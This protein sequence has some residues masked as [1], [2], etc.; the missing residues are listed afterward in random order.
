[1]DGILSEHSIGLSERNYYWSGQIIGPPYRIRRPCSRMNAFTMFAVLL[2]GTSL[3]I[4]DANTS[5]INSSYH[6]LFSSWFGVISC[7]ASLESRAIHVILLTVE[8]LCHHFTSGDVP[9]QVA[10]PLSGLMMIGCFA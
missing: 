3:H 8:M 10:F 6:N 4:I 1:M 7:S 9:L 5:V 2:Q